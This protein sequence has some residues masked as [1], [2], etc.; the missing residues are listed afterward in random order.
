VSLPQDPKAWFDVQG[1]TLRRV[2]SSWL[3]G[4]PVELVAQARRL[5]LGRR[6]L[7]KRLCIVSPVLFGLPEELGSDAA[8]GLHAGAWLA[9]RLREPLECAL[10]LGSLAMA[11]T[12]RT[13]VN[14]PEVVKLRAALGIERYA[15]VLAA[16][17]LPSQQAPEPARAD[18]DTRD[19]VDRIVR[20]GAAELAGFADS[21]HPAWGES[22]RL[23][24]ERGWWSDVPSPTLTAGAAEACLR[25]AERIPDSQTMNLA[26]ENL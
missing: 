21:L 13:L 12:V 19:I 26:G 2:H 20:C 14:R 18:H 6:W 1:E 22:V 11:A 5:S 23:T 17:A 7:A 4:I 25:A 8:A 3:P 16:P 24:F 9:P 15:R 10:D